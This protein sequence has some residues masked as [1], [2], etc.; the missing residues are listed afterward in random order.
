MKV[1]VVETDAQI[2]ATYDVMAQ[3]RPHISREEYLT[4]VRSLMESD[5]Y[6]LASLVDQGEVRAVAGFRVMNMLCCGRILYVDDLVTDERVRS[7]GYG[8]ELLRWLRK[9]GQRLGCNDLQ[10]ISRVTREQAHRFYF[11]EGMSIM[12]FHFRS[13][14]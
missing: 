7:I 14:L 5:R 4:H 11:R 12:C 6:V 1:Q 2:A 13:E 9:E 8:R 10:L 3:L